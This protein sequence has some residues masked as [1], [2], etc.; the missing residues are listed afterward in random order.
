MAAMAI[1]AV[2]GFI[3]AGIVLSIPFVYALYRWAGGKKSLRRWVR[4]IL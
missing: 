4:E 2:W 3:G 1:M